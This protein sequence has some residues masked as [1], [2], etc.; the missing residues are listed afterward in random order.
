[1]VLSVHICSNKPNIVDLLA[2]QLGDGYLVD[3]SDSLEKKADMIIVDVNLITE[4]QNIQSS[5]KRLAKPFLIIG[6]NWSDDKQIEAFIQGASGY[7]DIDKEL[8]MLSK[9]IESIFNGDIWIKRHLIPKVIK[10]IAA[11][12]QAPQF[13][14]SKAIDSHLEHLSNRELEVAKMIT[15]GKNNKQIAK[16]LNIS[17]RTVKAHLTSIFKKLNVSDRLHL[18]VLLKE[19]A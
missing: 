18:A 8:S 12:E 13:V 5:I 19:T 15:T 16:S 9:A 7:L 14:N 10:K 2:S 4:Q 1:M 11:S 3:S 6:N 17:E